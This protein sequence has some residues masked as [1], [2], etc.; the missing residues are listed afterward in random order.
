M[1]ED[2]LSGPLEKRII[3]IH[4]KPPRARNFTDFGKGR[5]HFDDTPEGLSDAQRVLTTVI[6]NDP[7]YK[8]HTFKLVRQ[9][10]GSKSL[11]PV[12]GKN[13]VVTT[14]VTNYRTAPKDIPN[15]LIKGTEVHSNMY[16]E[17]SE[18][19]AFRD[20]VMPFISGTELPRKSRNRNRIPNVPESDTPNWQHLGYSD[21]EA[22]LGSRLPGETS[23]QFIARHARSIANKRATAYGMT[24]KWNERRNPPKRVKRGTHGKTP[25]GKELEDIENKIA[26]S[27]TP[28]GKAVPRTTT[29]TT[30]KKATPKKTPTKRGR[31]STKPGAV[32][33][34]ELGEQGYP[35]TEPPAKKAISKSRA[36]ATQRGTRKPDTFF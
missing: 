34:R 17:A 32:A 3:A 25:L 14:A 13:G 10:L 12:K 6:S 19:N 4:V 20:K 1:S 36:R 16:S 29:K 2:N 30:P 22:M 8:G 27:K 33:L 5:I 26:A 35:V 31:P 15:T 24:Q 9:S 28:K 21:P 23:D 18:H 11:N 7:R